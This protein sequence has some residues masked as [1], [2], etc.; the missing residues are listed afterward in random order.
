[1]AT[2]EAARR[3]LKKWLR[4]HCADFETEQRVL[5]AL[6][7]YPSLIHN[8]PYDDDDDEVP[9]AEQMVLILKLFFKAEEAEKEKEKEAEEKERDR[10]L[11]LQLEQL[12]LDK[13]IKAAE[14]NELEEKKAR[15]LRRIKA[16]PGHL[17]DLQPALFQA[18][19]ST[20]KEP[21]PPVLSMLC[22]E[23]ASLERKYLVMAL[24]AWDDSLAAPSIYHCKSRFL[25]TSSPVLLLCFSL[26][27]DPE[28]SVSSLINDVL[29]HTPSGQTTD[30]G[31]T[32]KIKHPHHHSAPGH[33]GHYLAM[34]FAAIMTDTYDQ[35]STGNA[36]C[37]WSK[38][39][40]V[41]AYLDL[42]VLDQELAV[43][44]ET[45]ALF[46]AKGNSDSMHEL[47]WSAFYTETWNA[48][49]S[50]VIRLRPANGLSQ[51]D[52][53]K[54]R[55]ATRLVHQF[56]LSTAS[57]T[58][59]TCDAGAS[60]P[61]A[62]VAGESV[63]ILALNPIRLF[64][65]KKK[66]SLADFLAKQAHYQVQ[67]EAQHARNLNVTAQKD[68]L[69]PF[70]FEM[71]S[72]GGNYLLQLW[73]PCLASSDLGRL[74]PPGTAKKR[75]G[76]F[77]PI[78][79][80][81]M[82]RKPTTQELRSIAAAMLYLQ[83]KLGLQLI[84][85]GKRARAAYLVPDKQVEGMGWRVPVS[86]DQTLL[87]FHAQTDRHVLDNRETDVCI[88]LFDYSQRTKV[89][90]NDLTSSSLEKSQKIVEL[91]QR[92]RAPDATLQEI[93]NQ[94]QGAACQLRVVR[95]S[96]ECAILVYNYVPGTHRPRLEDSW[97]QMLAIL[98]LLSKVH[99]AGYL[100]GDIL[101]QNLVFALILDHLSTIIDWDM[102]Q[103]AT[104][105]SL[106]LVGYNH[107][108]FSNIRHA[109][110]RENQVM[111]QAHDCHSMGQLVDLWFEAEEF[112]ATLRGADAL[113]A[114]IL[115]AAPKVARLRAQPTKV[116]SL[117]ATRSPPRH[118]V[119]H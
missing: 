3:N 32:P 107:K 95:A 112:A 38:W 52:T 16:M 54:L 94:H 79:L 47:A 110:A 10:R 104:A 60:V 78:T 117:Q 26:C 103:L 17:Q 82:A 89:W 21:V 67:S 31:N 15:A 106:Y 76:Q 34:E 68:L 39:D 99:E 11:R 49:A 87:Q 20:L 98:R 56:P 19:S 92:R 102:A 28:E 23:S 105:N 6:K 5:S 25:A 86:V 35:L 69:Q 115:A 30:Y 84:T 85:D 97:Q 57:E 46:W 33:A 70:L 29:E 36:R 53:S 90:Y 73:V 71:M 75:V 88:K 101:P 72:Q 61:Q 77:V 111:Q 51:D 48:L 24:N 45:T 9:S 13:A 66:E 22:D 27:I 42:A 14:K 2:A 113:T 74:Y 12:S 91:A 118:G 43:F 44:A 62:T 50:N 109:D 37:D 100:H 93:I 81:A 65:M 8:L 114:S 108:S 96:A 41:A 7:R 64:E 40:D 1:M 18:I 83:L 119:E 4:T 58:V 116:A 59:V 63:V 55:K 80:V